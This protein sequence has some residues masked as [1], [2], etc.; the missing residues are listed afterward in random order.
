LQLICT[1]GLTHVVDVADQVK[2]HVL[3]SGKHSAVM[4]PLCM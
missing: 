3:H 4:C 2:Q 1:A